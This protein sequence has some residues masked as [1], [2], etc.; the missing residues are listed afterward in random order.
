VSK[1]R[2]SVAGNILLAWLV[3]IPASIVM[4]AVFYL[5]IQRLFRP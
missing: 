4:A 1:V 5:A 2:W 3:T